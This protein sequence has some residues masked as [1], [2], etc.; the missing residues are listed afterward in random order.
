MYQ[1]YSQRETIFVDRRSAGKSLADEL[2]RRGARYDAVL[3]LT[4]GGVP[5]GFEVAAALGIPLDVIVI[6]KLRTPNNP[7]LAMGAVSA[8]GAK[9]LREHI[10]RQLGISEAYLQK[11]TVARTA[12]AQEEESKYRGKNPALDIKGLSVLVVDDG[13]ATGS[14]VEAAVLSARKKGASKVTIATPVASGE[15]CQALGKVAD[16]IL[17]LS[18]PADFWAVGM[19]YQD[20]SQVPGEEVRS[21][22]DRSR[23][24]PPQ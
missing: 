2:R 16:D 14:S 12:E 23:S 15:S 19:F 10:I 24:S 22:I 7:E 1:R 18:T 4:R 20:F 13:I 21:L 11:E 6:K 17:C 9:V 5:L 8:D 3:G